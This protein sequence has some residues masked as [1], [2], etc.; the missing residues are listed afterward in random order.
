[1]VKK[2]TTTMEINLTKI[3]GRDKVARKR[4]ALEEIGEFLIQEILSSVGGAKSPIKGGAYKAT[5]SKSYKA[6]KKKIS[7]STKA[8]MELFGDMLDALD[9]RITPQKKIEVGFLEGSDQT[10]IDKADNHNKFS[11]AAKRTKLPARE[12][13]PKKGQVFKKTI[14]K[15]IKRIVREH[16]DTD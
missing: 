6:I 3:K 14:T 9:F 2:V 7:G 10:Q 13:I 12:F 5:L 15:E 4:E 1:M 16:A 8:N 11:S